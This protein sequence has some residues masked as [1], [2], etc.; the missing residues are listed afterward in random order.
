MSPN[1]TVARHMNGCQQSGQK[2]DPAKVRYVSG[3]QL[4]AN[5]SFVVGSGQSALSAKRRKADVR[6]ADPEKGVIR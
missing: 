6:S 2:F 5:V 3:S 1:A 4:H